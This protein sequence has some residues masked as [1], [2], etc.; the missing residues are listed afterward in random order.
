M[1][2]KMW[3]HQVDLFHLRDYRPH[4]RR[5]D[6]SV[7]IVLLN[8]VLLSIPTGTLVDAHCPT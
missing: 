1:L 2:R 3:G 6:H 8:V 7:L 4:A 5:E